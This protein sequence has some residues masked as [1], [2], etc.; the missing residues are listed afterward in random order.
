MTRGWHRSGRPFPSGTPEPPLTAAA[1]R[2]AK[3]FRATLPARDPREERRKGAAA[4]VGSALL[5]AL[6]IALVLRIEPPP[7]RPGPAGGWIFPQLTD[8]AGGG[9]G[10]DGVVQLAWGS[11]PEPELAVDDPVA[12]PIPEIEVDLPEITLDAPTT[13]QLVQIAPPELA[14]PTASG[15][16]GAPARGTG[17]GSGGGAGAG[18]G[19]GS[20][21]G[22]G[23]GGGGGD[24][25]RPPA[26]LTILVPP[27]ATAAVRGGSA[28]VRLQVDS[29][30]V[31]RG[32]DV[33]V[34]SGDRRYDEQLRRVALG[35]R[36]R[37]A[38]DA[39][40]RPVPY[41]FEVSVTF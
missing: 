20:G 30:G 37:P 25:I 26:P 36:F 21:S 29:A 9:G 12:P 18:A 41:P 7:P 23:T 35:W 17:A 4:S 27:A 19:P 34:S 6:L 31:V 2:I 3:E 39:A 5:H 11:L 14:V 28:K 24:G 10:D 16:G 32:A 13:D 38:R 1:P 40:N 33:V 22:V 8:E 15:A